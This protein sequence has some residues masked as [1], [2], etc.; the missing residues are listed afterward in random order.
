MENSLALQSTKINMFDPVQFESLQRLCKMYVISELVPETYRPVPNKR[1]EQQAIAN[2][3]IAIGMA[4]RMNADHLMVMQNLDVI[5]G[6]P[7]FS[8]KF[9]IG[10]VN[11]CGRFAPIRYKMTD[12]GEIKNVQYQEKVWVNGQSKMETRTYPNPIKNIQCIAYTT[13]RGSDEVLESSPISIE[14]AIK[15]GWYTKSGSKWPDMPV[16]MLQ[17]RAASFWQRTYAPELSLGMI[18]QEEARDIEDTE[19]IEIPEEKLKEKVNE[20]KKEFVPEK[21][22]APEKKVSEPS[23][24]SGVE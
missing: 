9:L 11:S 18:T 10:M 1:T 22:P 6:R 8:A 12:L 13:E 21:Q 16:L 17:Y 7:S 5:Q 15:Q 2:C 14:M 24:L 20:P 19:Y 23:F 3:V 4:Q